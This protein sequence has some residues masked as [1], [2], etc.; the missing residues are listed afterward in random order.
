[1]TKSWIGSETSRCEEFVRKNWNKDPYDCAMDKAPI[2][3]GGNALS[4]ESGISDP[5]PLDSKQCVTHV[6][7]TPI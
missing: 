4:M 3:I 6:E 2:G 1:M 5:T 7:D